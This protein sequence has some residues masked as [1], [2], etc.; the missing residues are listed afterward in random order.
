MKQIL[1][2]KVVIKDGSYQDVWTALFLG[3]LE[4]ARVQEALEKTK[5]VESRANAKYILEAC[6]LPELKSDSEYIHKNVA[7]TTI[8]LVKV[9][10]LKMWVDDD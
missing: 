3:D 1:V 6:G 4:L 10:K 8:G 7:G 5:Y 2:Y 9:S